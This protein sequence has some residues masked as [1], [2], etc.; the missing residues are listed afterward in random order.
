MLVEYTGNSA[1]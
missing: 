1:K